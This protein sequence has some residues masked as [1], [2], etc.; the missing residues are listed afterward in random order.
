MTKTQQVIDIVLVAV[1]SLVLVSM[2]VVFLFGLISPGRL[3][4]S[5]DD[6]VLSILSPA[7]DTIIGWAVGRLGAKASSNPS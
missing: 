1:L 6:K 3:I 5:E 4:G 2:V 7:F